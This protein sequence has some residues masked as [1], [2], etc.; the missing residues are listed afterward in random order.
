MRDPPHH[1]L[2]VDHRAQRAHREQ[3]S[4][5]YRNG[6]YRPEY[7]V[8]RYPVHGCVRTRAATNWIGKHELD[9]LRRSG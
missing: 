9:S 6:R 2:A 5:D 3:R 4:Y 8:R 1:P 7:A